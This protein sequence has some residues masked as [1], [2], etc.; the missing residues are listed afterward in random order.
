MN[1][2]KMYQVVLGRKLGMADNQKNSLF[3]ETR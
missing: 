2:L 1:G 3:N